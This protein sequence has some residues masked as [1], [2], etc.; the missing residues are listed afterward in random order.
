MPVAIAPLIFAQNIS[1]GTTL[2]SGCLQI[3]TKWGSDH[4]CYSGLRIDR[5]SVRR[6]TD[7]AL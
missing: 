1:L 6:I 3:A 7:V 5:S 2:T 4:E